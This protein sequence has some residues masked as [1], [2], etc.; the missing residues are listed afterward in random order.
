MSSD[1]TPLPAQ[2]LG[3][4][5]KRLWPYFADGKKGLIVSSLALLIMGLTEPAIPAL[6]QPLLDS[7]FKPGGHFQIWWVPAFLMGLF[8]IRG[9]A[10]FISAYALQWAGQIGT[11]HLRRAL[12]AHL[13]QAQVSLFT[14]SNASSLANTVVFEVQSGSQLLIAALMQA[15]KHGL[16][17]LALIGYLLYLN[18]QLTLFVLVTLPPVALIMR[19]M[20][21]RFHKL[22]TQSQNATDDLA[23]VVEENA[24]AHKVV[25]LHGAAAGQQARFEASSQI[26]RRLAVKSTAAQ[27]STTPLTQMLAAAALSAVI[28]IALWQAQNGQTSVGGFVAF[29]TAMLML[30]A[31]TRHL[32]DA[33]APL[34]R[35]LAAI[36]RGLGLLDTAPLESS[37]THKPAAG[38]LA[39]ADA[40]VAFENLNVRH[41]PRTGSPDPAGLALTN[42]SLH[43][44]SGEVVAL[45]GPSGSGKSTLLSLLPRFLNAESGQVLVGGVAVQDWHLAALRQQFALVAQDVVMFNDSIWANVALGDVSANIEDAACKVRIEQAL[46]A[47]HLLEFVKSLPQGLC[48]VVGHNAQALS[49]GQRQRLAIARAVYKNAPILLLDEATAALDSESERE[50]QKALDEVMQGRTTIV[51]AHRLSTIV[52]AHRIVVLDAGRIAEQGT[53]AELI[54]KG[55]LYAKLHALQFGA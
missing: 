2:S 26:L 8:A 52:N 20:S 44:H 49:G 3:Q 46:K 31:P 21:K 42:L 18:W 10:G 32:A 27:A 25:R 6:L 41:P 9:I 29:I 13:S 40:T 55:G 43:I 34:T 45:V 4:R 53:H 39:A 37:G 5:L 28:A 30:I 16:T 23:Y 1:S 47:A 38:L 17:A 51:V 36:E 22:V 19:M 15:L 50:V 12:F 35:G 33:A 24:L 7:G 54:A 11:L 14:Q 48:T